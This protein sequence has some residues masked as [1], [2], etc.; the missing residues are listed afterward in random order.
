M[1]KLELLLLLVTLVRGYPGSL[2][3]HV[4]YVPVN[5]SN[6]NYDYKFLTP[7]DIINSVTYVLEKMRQHIAL[8]LNQTM[9][10]A[11]GSPMVERKTAKKF[12]DQI[13]SI[14][15]FINGQKYVVNE[16]VIFKSNENTGMVYKVRVVDIRPA[17]VEEMK[18]KDRIVET[19]N[20]SREVEKNDIIKMKLANLVKRGQRKF[21][22]T[23]KRRRIP[24]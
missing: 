24:R 9:D 13:K 6:G 22:A 18:K 17:K 15:K 1:W 11:E 8:V 10:G 20:A 2:S 3:E 4:H 21:T 12:D 16:T 19:V 14:T 23:T 5:Q 7:V